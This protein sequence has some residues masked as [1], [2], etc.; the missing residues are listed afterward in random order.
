MELE[1]RHVLDWSGVELWN[2]T[3]RYAA[4][5]SN[6]FMQEPLRDADI[7]PI[8]TLGDQLFVEPQPLALPP[9]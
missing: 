8:Y 3:E 7:D 9:D 5:D 1:L 2:F 6:H 4:V